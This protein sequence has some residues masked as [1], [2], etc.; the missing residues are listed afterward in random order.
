MDHPP[1]SLGGGGG[2]G[3]RRFFGD[4]M[5]CEVRDVQINTVSFSM[6]Q[7]VCVFASMG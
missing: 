7:G 3:G 4:S 5:L 6:G 2:G 1:Q